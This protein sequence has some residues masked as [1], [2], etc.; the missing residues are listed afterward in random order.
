MKK[1][2]LSMEYY[3]QQIIILIDKLFACGATIDDSDLIIHTL[4]GLTTAYQPYKTAINTRSMADPV[5]LD[6]LHTLLIC[7]ELS[8]EETPL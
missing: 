3:L 6:E 8:L 7:E 1:S 4:D 2:S 5:T